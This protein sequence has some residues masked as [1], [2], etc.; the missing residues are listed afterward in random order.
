M[1]D[2]AAAVEGAEGPSRPAENAWRVRVQAC[3]PH[4]RHACR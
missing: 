2:L 3:V 4:S 1:K